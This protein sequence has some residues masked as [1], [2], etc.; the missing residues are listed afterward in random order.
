MSMS[1]KSSIP[2][3]AIARSAARFAFATAL[4]LVVFAVFA[5]TTACGSD[6]PAG[7]RALIPTRSPSLTAAPTQVSTPP[8]AAPTPTP[9]SDSVT[10]YEEIPPIAVHLGQWR[11]TDFHRFTVD[12]DEIVSGGPGRNGIPPIYQPVFMSLQEAAQLEWLT[13]DHPVAVVEVNGDARAYP[14]G[15]LTFHEVVND[16]IGGEP[17]LVT[18]CPLCYTT[19]AFSREFEG[20]VLN[21]GTTGNVRLS[22]LIMWDDQTESWWQQADGQAIVGEY[23]GR[24]LD[25]VPSYTTSIAEFAASWPDGTVLSPASGNPDYWQ[26]Y[27]GTPYIG[28][29]SPNNPPYLFIGQPDD[30][31]GPTERILGV[32]IGD[33]VVAFPFGRLQN[34]RIIHTTV[35]GEPIV[36]FWKPGTRSALDEEEIALSHDPGS[37]AAFDPR[38]DGRALEFTVIDD[39]IR[40]AQSGSTW[41]L[42]GIATDGPLA[43]TQLSPVSAENGLWFAWA[44]FKPHTEIYTGS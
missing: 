35:G 2:D 5:I 9:G 32:E 42:L 39:A 33:S 34:E 11:V 36:V 6:T 21:F 40:D 31:L 1:L 25:F 30:R 38:V 7:D 37:A 23:A 27:G 20:E 16:I 15:I 44:A 41:T 22:N 10:V 8:T 28:Y 12:P 17:I 43:G 4:G 14:L 26:V 29:D 3:S 18:Y 13:A 24:F 19:L